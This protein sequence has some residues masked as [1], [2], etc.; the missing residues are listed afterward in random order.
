MVMVSGLN[1]AVQNH[2]HNWQYLVAT[3]SVKHA[4]AIIAADVDTAIESNGAATGV[5]TAP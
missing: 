1:L 4:S 2:L 5:V 3:M